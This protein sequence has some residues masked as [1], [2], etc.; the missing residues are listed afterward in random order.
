MRRID[1]EAHFYTK[2]YLEAMYRNTGYPRFTAM[3]EAKSTKL[4]YNEEVGQPYGDLLLKDL[5]NMG[6]E[7]L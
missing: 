2:E 6:E 1:F 4:W 3:Q 5:L 7:R